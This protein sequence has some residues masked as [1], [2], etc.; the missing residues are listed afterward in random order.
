MG[1]VVVLDKNR[2]LADAQAEIKSLRL[3]DRLKQKA[4]DEVH[5][6]LHVLVTCVMWG[7]TIFLWVSI[8]SGGFS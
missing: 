8:H 4:V 2:G 3:S 6:Q 7:V 5:K 1:G